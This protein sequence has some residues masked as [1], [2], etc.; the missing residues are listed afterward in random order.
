MDR[1]VWIKRE[2]C[3]LSLKN[4]RCGSNK[5]SKDKKGIVGYIAKR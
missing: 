2:I 3:P 5:I 4:G 1:G